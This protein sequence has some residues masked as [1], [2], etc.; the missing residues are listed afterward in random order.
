MGLFK[1]LQQNKVNI[2]TYEY[3]RKKKKLLRGL[4]NQK[5]VFIKKCF[6]SQGFLYKGKI[7]AK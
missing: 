7:K 3:K 1:S 2:L 6:L 4:K 5:K